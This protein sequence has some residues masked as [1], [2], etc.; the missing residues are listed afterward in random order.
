MNESLAVI[1]LITR[2]KTGKDAYNQYIYTETSRTVYAQTAPITRSEYMTA[3]QLGIAPE[4]YFIISAFDYSGETLLEY[5]GQKF[6][7]YRTYNRNEN[8]TEIYCTYAAGANGG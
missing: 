4:H 5:K 2:T 6:R 3:G 8:E 7:I 1:K